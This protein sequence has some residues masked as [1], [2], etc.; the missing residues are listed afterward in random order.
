VTDYAHPATR[1]TAC[2]S[3][4]Y[5]S[6][7]TAPG[8]DGSYAFRVVPLGALDDDAQCRPLGCIYPLSSRAPVPRTTHASAR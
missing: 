1:Y 5:G 7:M 8:G 4:V 6:H 3:R 2:F